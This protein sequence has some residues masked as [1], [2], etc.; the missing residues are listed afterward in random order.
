[1]LLDAFCLPR[2]AVQKNHDVFVGGRSGPD[3][4]PGTQLLAD[5]PYEEMPQ[6]LEKLIPYM[7]R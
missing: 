7:N 1:M 6:I 4:Q 3:A 5:V 2:K